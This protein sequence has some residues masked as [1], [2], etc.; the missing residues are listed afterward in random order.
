MFLAFYLVQAILKK[1]MVSLLVGNISESLN[2]T[3]DSL[4]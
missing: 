4:V 1:K 2:M 3:Y